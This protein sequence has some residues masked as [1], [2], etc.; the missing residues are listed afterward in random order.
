MAVRSIIFKLTKGDTPDVV[1]M[2][3]RVREMIEEA[4]RSDGVEEILKIGEDAKS[5]QDLFDEA[6]LA[7]INRI[8]LPNTKIKLLQ[9]LLAKAIGQLRK[10]NRMKGID[11]SRRMQQLV[12]QYN[13]RSANDICEARY[14]KKWLN[15]LPT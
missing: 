10:V 6:Y 3:N 7:K 14:M 2:N 9:K 5:E 8:K 15:N 12:E 13:D 1:Q 4:L 11:F